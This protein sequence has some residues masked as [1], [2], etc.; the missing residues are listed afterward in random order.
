MDECIKNA[1]EIVIA[2]FLIKFKCCGSDWA[3]DRSA[4]RDWKIFFRFCCWLGIQCQGWDCPVCLVS[5]DKK[6][7][8]LLVLECSSL[9]ERIVMNFKLVAVLLQNIKKMYLSIH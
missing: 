8:S 9:K 5:P 1:T 3:L 2:L 7:F 6:G 4:I